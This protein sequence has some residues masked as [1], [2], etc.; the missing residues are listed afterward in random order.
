MTEAAPEAKLDALKRI[1]AEMRSVIVAFSGGVD[2]TFLAAVARDV[3]GERALA[4]TGVSPSVPPSE[5]EE[6]KE[7]ARGIGI[8]HELIDTQEM[9]DPNYVANNPN[10][11]FHCK[12]ELYGRLTA[13]ARERGFDYVADGCNLDDT[14]D[15]RPGRR[16]A[17]QHGVRSPLVE[18]G[19][20]KDDIRALSRERGLPTWDKPAMA[21]LSSRIPYGTPVTVEALDRIGEAEAYLRS[22]GLRELRLRALAFALYR[23]ARDEDVL[24]AG[25]KCPAVDLLGDLVSR[26]NLLLSLLHHRLVLVLGEERRLVLELQVHRVL[27]GR[28]LV[29]V[30]PGLPCGLRAGVHL[31][32]V[33]AVELRGLSAAAFTAE[34]LGPDSGVLIPQVGVGRKGV[35]HL[36]PLALPLWVLL[37]VEEAVGHVAGADDGAGHEPSDLDARPGQAQHR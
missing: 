12:D 17:A 10:R 31:V 14:G 29:G 30:V 19:L 13:M 37:A 6:A 24:A 27:D 35:Q 16:A 3:L 21:C 28:Q 20:T 7:L 33:F 2:S 11:C 9:D 32:P 36:R 34:A 23:L 15:F 4:I 5:V 26:E 25:L 18:A 22:L 8:A 1:M